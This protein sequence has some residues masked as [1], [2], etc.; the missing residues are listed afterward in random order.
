MDAKTKVSRAITKLMIQYPFY[1]SLALSSKVYQDDSIPTMCTDGK[2]IRWSGNFVDELEPQHVLFVIAHEVMHIALMHPLRIGS[3][4][5]ERWNIA[6]DY[7]INAELIDIFGPDAM[8]KG[9]L[10]DPEYKGKS[11]EQIYMVLPDDLDDITGGGQSWDFGGIQEPKDDQG[12]KLQP[13]DME[14]LEADITQKTLMAADAA[15]A[16]GK[17]PSSVEELVAIMRR[18]QVDLDTVVAKFVGGEQ[19]NDYTYRRIN[20]RDYTM[21]GMVNRTITNNSVGHTVVAIDS[22]ASVTT[23]EQEYFLGLV[24]HFIEDKQPESV[25]IIT[26]DVKVQ[27]VN[28]Y[29]RGEAVPQLGLTGRGGTLVSPVF[30]YIEDE[31]IP[32]DQMI[33]LS[34]MQIFDFPKQPAHYPVLWVSSWIRSEPAP[35]GKSTWMKAA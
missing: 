26:W 27:T 3:R 30:K 4:D 2:S 20:K 9:G 23:E 8:P 17:L 13:S 18:S 31:H 24:N 22:S 16:V 15:K 28:T 34:D 7:A 14:Q 10:Y 19:P 29:K 35:W 5:P 1:G 12:Q 21:Y 6:C 11:A 25:T 32:C 33:V